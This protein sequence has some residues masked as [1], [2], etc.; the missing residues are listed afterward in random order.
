MEAIEKSKEP[1]HTLVCFTD[2]ETG[3]AMS[4]PA[5]YLT[6]S[7][8]ELSSITFL[9]LTNEI[10]DDEQSVNDEKYQTKAFKEL[11]NNEAKNK[12]TV[13]TFI[14]KTENYVAEIR[15]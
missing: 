12:I 10:V 9:H 13:R 8:S 6:M 14:K 2:V 3:R 4:V 5:A 15:K 7:G 1:I 11:I